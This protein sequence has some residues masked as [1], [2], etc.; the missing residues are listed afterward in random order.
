MT[1]RVNAE[2]FRIAY[3]AVSKES[4]RYYLNGVHIEKHPEAGAV[5]VTTDGHRMVVVHDPEAEV[6]ETAI[7]KLPAYALAEC[8]RKASKTMGVSIKRFL[9]VDVGARSATVSEQRSQKGGSTRTEL[10]VTSHQS[11]IEGT[12]PDWRKV[13]PTGEMVA[14]GLSGFNPKIMASLAQFGA[15][16]KPAIGGN[17]AM[18]FMRPKDKADDTS[19]PIIVRFDGVQSIFA[20]IMPMRFDAEPQLPSFFTM[21]EPVALNVAA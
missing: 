17:G 9:E 8:A 20:L 12:F 1:I 13:V 2:L 16:V 5:L 19:G 14:M 10:L 21:P 11:V 15:S 4:T 6:T 18:Y 7:V 3:A